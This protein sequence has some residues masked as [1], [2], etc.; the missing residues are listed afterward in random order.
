[1]PPLSVVLLAS[2]GHIKGDVVQQRGQR[3]RKDDELYPYIECFWMY[4]CY[5]C[6]TKVSSARRVC[7][8]ALVCVL[9]INFVFVC[10]YVPVCVCLVIIMQL[11]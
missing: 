3:Q 4:V 2:Q 8:L 9:C 5:L 6:D 7:V 11:H 1:M 10:V